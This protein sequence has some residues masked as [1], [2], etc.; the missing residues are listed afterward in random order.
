MQGKGY[1][2]LNRVGG[3]QS[4]EAPCGGGGRMKPTPSNFPTNGT[5]LSRSKSLLIG[6]TLVLLLTFTQAAC[7]GSSSGSATTPTTQASTSGGGSG[8]GTTLTASPDIGLGP[9]PCPDAV[10]ATTYWDSIITTQNGVTKVEKVTCSNLIGN[11]TIQAL[12]TVRYQGTGA[13]LD[14]YVFNNITSPSPSQLFKLQNL[15]KGDAKISGYNSIM[16]AEVDQNSSINA[17]KNNASLTQ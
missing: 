4:G 1:H 12:V 17:G 10:K 2:T 16:T 7:S 15:Y 14:V 8:S 3:S 11:P 13:T 6:V 5:C 9:R